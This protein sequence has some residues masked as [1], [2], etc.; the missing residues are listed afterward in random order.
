MGTGNSFLRDFDIT[1]TQQALEA[2]LNGKPHPIDV[3]RVRHTDGELHYINLLSVGFSAE[4]GALTNRRFKRLG[5]GGYALAVIV[6]LV[7]LGHPKYSYQTNTGLK[8]TEP[9][10]LLSF[11]NSRY[12]GG[13]MMMAPTAEVTDGKVDII[14]IGPMGRS[15][16]LSCFPKIYQ[17][18]HIHLEEIEHDRAERVVF[19]E[20]PKTNV[21]V[22]GEIISLQL[23]ELEVLPSAL[24]IIR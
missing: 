18:T 15:R 10:T 7:R 21:M 24:E 11:S 20:M 1:N 13:T 17:G 8:R 4:A 23:Q 19:Q 22:D 9:C 2:L 6:N 14:H 16:L 5:L 12:T 3:I